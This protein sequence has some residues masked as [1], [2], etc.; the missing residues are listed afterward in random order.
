MKNRSIVERTGFAL[1]G[2]VAAW[3]RE[4]S[5]R[6]QVVYAAVAA[7]ARGQLRPAPIWW[8]VVA[9][10]SA[11][12]LSLE[13]INSSL[14]AVIDRVHPA[15]HPEIKAAKDMLA[16]AVLAISMAALIVG[17]GLAIDRV[18]VLLNDWGLTP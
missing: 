13:L 3:R 9:L 8:A 16:G 4:R 12:V 5:F 11:L 1:A 14:E 10:T 7:A 2:W 15:I 18:P 17:G 6:T